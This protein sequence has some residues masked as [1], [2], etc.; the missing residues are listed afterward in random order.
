MKGRWRERGGEGEGEGEGREE[1]SRQRGNKMIPFRTH[2]KERKDRLSLNIELQTSSLSLSSPY[3]PLAFSLP[4]LHLSF[5]S[6]YLL[7]RRWSLRSCIS[8][9]LMHITSRSCLKGFTRIR[10][11][12]VFEEGT[13]VDLRQRPPLLMCYYSFF[14]FCNQRIL[15]FFY[16]SVFFF[17]V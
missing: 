7:L 9:H 10:S 2:A 13:R 8:V 4:L 14:Y 6:P 11:L 12:P 1:K 3:S 15:L 16:F 17:F 5:P